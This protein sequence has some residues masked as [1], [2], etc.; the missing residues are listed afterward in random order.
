MFEKLIENEIN[1]INSFINFDNKYIELVK[2]LDNQQIDN[3]YKT[4]FSSEVIWWI[5]QEN[6]KRNSLLNFNLKKSDYKRIN[7]ELNLYYYN[8]TIFSTSDFETILKNAI[9]L[10]LNFI[11]RPTKTLIWFLFKNE[12][13]KPISEILLRLNFFGL[14]N[15][16]IK[17]VRS[18]VLESINYKED[19]INEKNL[20]LNID[21]YPDIIISRYHLQNIL[22]KLKQSYL[23]DIKIDSLL[24]PFYDLAFLFHL[25]TENDN[26]EIPVEAVIIYLDDVGFRDL[27]NYFENLCINQNLIKFT[28]N[29]LNHQISSFLIQKNQSDEKFSKGSFVMVHNEYSKTEEQNDYASSNNFYE[30]EIVKKEK[31]EFELIVQPDRVELIRIA[32]Q[33]SNDLLKLNLNFDE[34]N[35]NLTDNQKAI[36]EITKYIFDEYNSLFKKNYLIKPSDLQKCKIDEIIIFADDIQESTL[37]LEFGSFKKI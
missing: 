15:F 14:D 26:L 19:E 24:K 25:E 31:N 27:R 35:D 16:L 5:Y 8:N 6:L 22:N 28:L 34:S 2:V 20:I 33:L 23:Q 18:H 17:K 11:L 4:F 36:A 9:T 3:I 13:S 37:E 7:E 21:A 1:R 10:R 32:R 12:I 30:N 29:E